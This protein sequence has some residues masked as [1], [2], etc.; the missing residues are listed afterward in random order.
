[1]TYEGDDYTT[2]EVVMLA[3]EAFEDMMNAWTQALQLFKDEC[4]A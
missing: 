2:L 1:M 4:E 3:D